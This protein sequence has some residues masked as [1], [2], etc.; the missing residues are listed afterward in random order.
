M[1]ESCTRSA[2]GR[3]TQSAVNRK[4]RD[5]RLMPDSPTAQPCSRSSLGL[6]STLLGS[7]Q[8]MHGPVLAPGEAR[9]RRCAARVTSQRPSRTRREPSSTSEHS[10]LQPGLLQAAERDPHENHSEAS[11]RRKTGIDGT[12]YQSMQHRG[13]L[14]ARKLRRARRST[15]APAAIASARRCQDRSKHSTVTRRPV[16]V[17]CSRARQRPVPG[18]NASR[19]RGANCLTR[20]PTLESNRPI[21]NA[22]QYLSGSPREPGRARDRMDGASRAR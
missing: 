15:A 2:S 4:F 16:A 14:T 11:L 20:T 18:G 17:E 19:G 9:E 8:V 6:A 3:V 12:A 5:H 1:R 13:A 22:R 7:C 10:C 21:G